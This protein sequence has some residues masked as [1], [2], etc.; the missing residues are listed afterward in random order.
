MLVELGPFA[1]TL[2]GGLE[3]E[4]AWLA[5]DIGSRRSAGG[6]DCD[7]EAGKRCVDHRALAS[8]SAA[9]GVGTKTW[10]A[11][12]AWNARR[13][14]WIW[15]QAWQSR[16][17]ASHARNL[18]PAPHVIFGAGVIQTLVTIPLLE[19]FGGRVTFSIQTAVQALP[20]LNGPLEVGRGNLP[21]GNGGLGHLNGAV[22]GATRAGRS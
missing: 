10:Y 21:A 11:P 17:Q 15:I 1:P 7:M 2:P 13:S 3:D 6:T 14:I 5:E 12:N 4:D 9:T 8:R 18:Q 16:W 20:H 22:R 19:L